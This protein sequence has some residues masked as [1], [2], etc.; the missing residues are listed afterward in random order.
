MSLEGILRPKALDKSIIVSI[1]LCVHMYNQYDLHS[2]VI[3][4]CVHAEL[5]IMIR[6]R[7]HFLTDLVYGQA[8]SNF[9]RQIY[10]TFSM[11]DS[12]YNVLFLIND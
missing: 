11:I 10:C 4:R 7:G 12:L 9:V 5:K 3:M 6:Q 8:K 1:L 2:V